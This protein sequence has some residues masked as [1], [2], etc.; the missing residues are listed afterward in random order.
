MERILF[1]LDANAVNARRMNRNLNEL[2]FLAETGVIDIQ[3][4]EV[5]N[6]EASAGSR[7]RSDKVDEYTWA[8]LT[9]DASL[10]DEW[11]REIQAAVFPFGVRSDSQRNDIEVLLT[12]KLAG[13]VLV[14]TDGASKTQPRGI[15][16]SSRE[17]AALGIN[18]LS[19]PDALTFAKRCSE[20]L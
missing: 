3:F 5:A 20:R 1:H 7:L 13:A 16:G 14:T 18:V 10:E 12:A 4:S 9:A 8:G 19:P 6:K 17:L 15:L 11:R 2:E